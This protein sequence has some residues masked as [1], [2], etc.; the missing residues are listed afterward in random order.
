[1]TP[2]VAFWI[3]LHEIDQTLKG[4]RQF[5]GVPPRVSPSHQAARVCD[6]LVKEERSAHAAGSARQYRASRLQRHAQMRLWRES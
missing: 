6:D 5:L 4:H 2:Q 3:R 1:M